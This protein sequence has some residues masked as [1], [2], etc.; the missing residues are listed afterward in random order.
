[1]TKYEYNVYCDESCHLE[2][3]KIN[4]MG[5]GAVWCKKEDLYQINLDIKNIKFKYGLKSMAEVKWGMVSNINLKLY[6]EILNYFF[7]NDKL[8][9]RGYFVDKRKLE[10]EKYHQTHDDFYYKCYFGL[11][12]NIFNSSYNY[13]IYIDIKDHSSYRKSKK[14]ELVCRNAN[15]DFAQKIINKVQP[16]RSDESQLLQI[17]DIITGAICYLNRVDKTLLSNDSKRELIELIKRR[18]NFSLTKSTFPSEKKFNL[19]FFG[20]YYNYE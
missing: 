7:N 4:I 6:T 14:L 3:D 19:F 9:Y 20:D 11:L 5:L 17:A 1:M 18:S 10:H 2:N 8:F 12:Q 13:N 15:H 16:V